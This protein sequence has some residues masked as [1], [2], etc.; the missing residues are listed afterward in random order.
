MKEVVVFLNTTH[1][2]NAISPQVEELIQSG[3]TDFIFLHLAQEVY[4]SFVVAGQVIKGHQDKAGNIGHSF[5]TTRSKAHTFSYFLSTH[6][7]TSAYAKYT[8]ASGEEMNVPVTLASLVSQQGQS[9]AASKVVHKFLEM[10]A[11]KL[12]DL[13]HFTSPKQ[14]YLDGELAA[15]LR[16]E[17]AAYI[18]QVIDT[19]VLKIFRGKVEVVLL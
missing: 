11:I 4:C 19:N 2:M 12:S 14:I 18:Q 9:E 13:V 17:H 1:S 8:F 10:V 15:T 7:L 16:T 5:I 3:K 6:F